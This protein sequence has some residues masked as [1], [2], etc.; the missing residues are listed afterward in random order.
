MADYNFIK[1]CKNYNIKNSK[2]LKYETIIKRSMNKI[3]KLEKEIDRDKLDYEI[4][5]NF[6]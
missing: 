5:Y 4:R 6:F 3:K 1:R 2:V